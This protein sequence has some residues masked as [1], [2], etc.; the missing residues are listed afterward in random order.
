MVLKTSGPDAVTALDIDLAHRLGGTI[1]EA[2]ANL[3]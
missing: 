1:A 2:L 3:G